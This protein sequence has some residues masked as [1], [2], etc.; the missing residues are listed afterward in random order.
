MAQI[1]HFKPKREVDAIENVNAFIAM[2]KNE[3]TV[4][5]A[6]LDWGD[7]KWPISKTIELRSRKSG[8][9]YW[10]RFGDDSRDDNPVKMEKPFVDFAKAYLR[11][12][13]GMKHVKDLAS[14]MGALKALGQALV[15]VH[16][17][18]CVTNIDINV[19]NEAQRLAVDY[20]CH[21]NAASVCA[22]L[23]VLSKFLNDN[24]LLKIPPMRWVRSVRQ[25][26]PGREPGKAYLEHRSDKL[27]TDRSLYALGEIY[28]DPKDQICKVIS[29][30][31]VILLSNPCRISEVLSMRTDCVVYNHEGIEGAIGL[32]WFPAKGGTPLT[33][34]VPRGWKELTLEALG[35]ILNVTEK[36]REIALWYEDNPGEM[37]LPQ[38]YSY[39]RS[40]E[41]IDHVALK[42]LLNCGRAHIYH[43]IFKGFGI[44]PIYKNKNSYRVRFK[45]IEKYVLSLLPD[46]FPYFHKESGLKYSDCLLVFPLHWFKDYTKAYENVMIQPVSMSTVCRLFGSASYANTIFAR[47][48]LTEEDG[49][50]IKISTHNFRH[51]Q[52][53][54]SEYGGIAQQTR[55]YFAGRKDIRHNQAYSHA[56]KVVL[57]EKALTIN[58]QSDASPSNT[59][60]TNEIYNQPALLA[61]YLERQL[62]EMVNVIDVG[63]C[64]LGDGQICPK[65]GDHFLCSNS[66]FV[67]GDSRF[68]QSLLPLINKMEKEIADCQ[69]A[70]PIVGIDPSLIHHK[71]VLS[72]LKGLNAIN[73]NPDIPDNSFVKLIPGKDFS[74]IIVAHYE[75]GQEYLE[76]GQDS[77]FP[78]L[79]VGELCLSV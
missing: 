17:V 70:H 12:S 20:Y 72:V 26:S 71:Q 57:A 68:S 35:K 23:E 41:Y 76:E 42:G 18:P 58:D 19:L 38:E 55:A 4:F 45:D 50:P 13:Y 75:R 28:N 62:N 46:N 67:K 63:F 14:Q 59:N 5:G 27:P 66:L 47:H 77:S 16:S 1:I 69:E 78:L 24:S 79:K 54:V 11:Y 44:E 49:S 7:V 29:S 74:Q 52:D 25:N 6:N 53:T 61:E 33:K 22:K 10:Y 37:Y 32:R 21:N 73:E 2:A 15:N 39:L 8:N 31:G 51:Y 40:E 34:P 65:I 64:T 36:A 48:G 3:L 56:D 43:K 30:I 60:F 9:Q